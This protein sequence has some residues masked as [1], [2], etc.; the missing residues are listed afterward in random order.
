MAPPAQGSM[1]QISTPLVSALL[2][3]Q[4]AET[5]DDDAQSAL[6]ALNVE[7][8]PKLVKAARDIDLAAS[9]LLF[10]LTEGRSQQEVQVDPA[11]LKAFHDAHAAWGAANLA[12]I[13]DLL[14]SLG[15]ESRATFIMSGESANASAYF[16]VVDLM[17]TA[18]M[19]QLSNVV[20]NSGAEPSQA[21]AELSL[22]DISRS[23][24]LT[25]AFSQVFLDIS[26]LK[27]SAA[28]YAQDFSLAF[29]PGLQA[30]DES[31]QQRTRLA[32]DLLQAVPVPERLQLLVSN[33]FSDYMGLTSMGSPFT[34]VL[35]MRGG[36]GPGSAPGGGTAPGA[37]GGGGFQGPGAQGFQG[38]GAQGF[39]GPGAQGF[40]GPG[41]G[42]VPGDPQGAAPGRWGGNSQ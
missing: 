20:E 24:N 25:N 18:H 14:D 21:T 26:T 2:S 9:D 37:A 42:I 27:P 36:N 32:L 19:A 7:L 38:P 10:A 12:G 34:S 29:Q 39:Q 13:V 4:L 15:A 30:L 40:Q 1:P 41:A 11:T 31:Q 8:Q 16:A 28:T 17:L 33:T 3:P 23:R 5:L 6:A 22:K 35:L